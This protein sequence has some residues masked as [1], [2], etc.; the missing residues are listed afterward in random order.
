[1]RS[2]GAACSPCSVPCSLL[3]QHAAFHLFT[4]WCFEHSHSVYLRW[5]SFYSNNLLKASVACVVLCGM[6][7]K[8]GFVH[9][10]CMCARSARLQASLSPVC[11][12]TVL[13]ATF[14]QL[15]ISAD[16]RVAAVNVSCCV[17]F[18]V[19][20]QQYTDTACCQPEHMVIM[21][22]GDRVLI[23]IC[24]VCCVPWGQHS[25]PTLQEAPQ[26]SKMWCSR[27][28]TGSWQQAHPCQTTAKRWQA[29]DCDG[30]AGTLSCDGACARML[31]A[32]PLSTPSMAELPKET[33]RVHDFCCME[34]NTPVPRPCR[35]LSKQILCCTNHPTTH[36]PSPTIHAQHSV[37]R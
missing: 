13:F 35:K 12:A 37:F 14:H 17:A 6:S 28:A 32:P 30:C 9:G 20:H 34:T 23:Y 7:G 10:T 11:F 26:L 4:Q 1:M 25:A 36:A 21:A 5:G 24:A 18:F 29:S 16:G 2:C 31:H 15:F 19:Q 22:R 27:A 8:A 33:I 3:N